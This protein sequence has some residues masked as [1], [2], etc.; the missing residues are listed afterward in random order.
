M[1]NRMREFLKDLPPETAEAYGRKKFHRFENSGKVL[2]KAWQGKQSKPY[3]FYVFPSV[4]RR[5]QW[6]NDQKSAEDAIERERIRRIG[7]R[8]QDLA[9][10]S[11]KLTVGTILHASWGYDQTNCDFYQVIGRKGRTVTLREIGCREVHTPNGNSSMSDMRK[12]AKD[13]FCGEPFRRRITSY[14]VKI[15]H[16]HASP[17]DP[18]RAYYCSWYA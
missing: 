13:D 7:R 15:G 16:H 8:D 9:E 4:E 17:C 12:P 14:G 18:S 10:M 11:D 1:E 2:I 5:E 6:I 3:A